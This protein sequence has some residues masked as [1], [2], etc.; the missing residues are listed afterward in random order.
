VATP[1]YVYSYAFGQLVS[2]A[3]YDLFRSGAPGFVEA[4]LDL[5]R[6]GGSEPPAALL[7]RVGLDLSGRAPWEAGISAIAALLDEARRLYAAGAE[8]P[9]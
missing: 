6:A 4:Y 9:G 7:G 1:F 5:L 8:A 3:L 2:L